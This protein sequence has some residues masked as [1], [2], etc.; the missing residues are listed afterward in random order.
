[1]TTAAAKSKA[2]FTHEPQ[3]SRKFEWYTPPS[4]FELLHF[5]EF[6]LDPA[7]PGT[8]GEGKPILPWIPAAKLYTKVD[9]GLL[10]P[11]HGRVWLN[12]PYG[13]ET[14]AWL[15]RLRLHGNGIALLF[16]RTDT[17]WF[18]TDA[19]HADAICFLAGR[20][21]F[22]QGEEGK[23]HQVRPPRPACRRRRGWL[24]LY[25]PGLWR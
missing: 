24:R 15:N 11:W 13:K 4:I 21:K 12:P 5:P 25:T 9:N 10:R 6:D 20:V 22:V 14:E 7:S 16:A 1:M 23:A 18:H 17:L 2:G 8:D 3:N 19:I